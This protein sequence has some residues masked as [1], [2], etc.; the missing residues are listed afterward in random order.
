MGRKFFG[1]LKLRK[2]P[3]LKKILKAQ[4]YLLILEYIDE[5]VTTM[6]SFSIKKL[7]LQMRGGELKV[8]WRKL[9]GS[10]SGAPKWLFIIYLS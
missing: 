3:G 7:Y 2:H 10:N 8:E 5:N 6:D 4:K 1:V 9:G